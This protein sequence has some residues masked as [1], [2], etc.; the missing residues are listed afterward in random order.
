MKIRTIAFLAALQFSNAWVVTAPFQNQQRQPLMSALSMADV[1]PNTSPTTFREAE[2][3]GLRLMQEGNYEEA[4]RGTHLLQTNCGVC[5]CVL[6]KN[7]LSTIYIMNH[8]LQGWNEITWFPAGR[9][10]N[11]AFIRTIASW[12]FLWWFGVQLGVDAR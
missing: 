10:S 1:E 8:S 5:V 12:R 9:D 4:L 6:S 7:S 3:L 11:K 2:V